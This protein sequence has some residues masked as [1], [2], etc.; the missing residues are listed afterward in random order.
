MEFV[1]FP[2]IPRIA[3]NVVITEKIDGTNAQVAIED[4]ASLSEVTDT[5]WAKMWFGSRNRWLGHIYIPDDGGSIMVQHCDQDNAGFMKWGVANYKE[6]LKLGI[7]QHFGEWWGQG[8]QRGYGL[9]EKRFSLFNAGRWQP[10]Y[11]AMMEGHENAFPKCC[12]VVPTLS[13]HTFD[14]GHIDSVMSSL[15]ETGSLA[16]PGYMDPEGVV[17]YHTQSKQMYKK[18]FKMDD[19]GKEAA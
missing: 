7:G 14:V 13:I 17:I 15:K 9:T 18:T 10:A 3:R 19:T 8:I 2:K 12:H 1:P 5:R 11:Q 4:Y 6:L 16:A